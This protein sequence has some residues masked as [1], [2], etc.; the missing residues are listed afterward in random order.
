MVP[1]AWTGCGGLAAEI[2]GQDLLGLGEAA[3]PG[4]P[5]VGE[6]QPPCS[7]YEVQ[8][9]LKGRGGSAEIE[10]GGLRKQGLLSPSQ[11]LS[12]TSGPPHLAL[13]PQ[14]NCYGHVGQVSQK[15]TGAWPDQLASGTTHKQSPQQACSKLHFTYPNSKPL[16]ISQ[17]TLTNCLHW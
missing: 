4:T 10:P 12:T 1:S 2:K 6:A 17:A 11:S 3:A 5:T 9:R 13:V 14:G 8:G 16:P 15:T 7:L